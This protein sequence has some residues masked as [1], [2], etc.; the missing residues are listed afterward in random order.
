MISMAL[1][2]QAGV[3]EEA[4]EAAG[5]LMQQKNFDA[6]FRQILRTEGMT[7]EAA[8]N[9]QEDPHLFALA[10]F[11]AWMPLLQKDYAS[12]GLPEQVF[13]DSI[14]DVGIWSRAYER[15]I[16]KPG[17]GEWDWLLLT[18]RRKLFRLGR[19]Q[20]EPRILESEIPGCL[21]A[22]APVL[23]VHIPA[24]EP[25][26]PEKVRNSLKTAVDFF[27]KYEKKPY[28]AF[29]CHSWLLAEELKQ[30]LPESSGILQFQRLFTVYA[31]DYGFSQAEERVFGEILEDP[32]AY[33][34]GTSLQRNLRQWRMEGKKIGMG[35]GLLFLSELPLSD[36]RS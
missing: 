33:P 22:G 3:S 20:Y 9:R 36:R 10:V 7:L 4:L 6:E 27:E 2:R 31:E 30:M 8:A 21:P 15:S 35:A 25:L 24:E 13:R 29:H 19:L 14:R 11:L 1:A 32:A 16:G 18:F 5:D 17:A 28:A 23:E 34:T 26:K 12:R